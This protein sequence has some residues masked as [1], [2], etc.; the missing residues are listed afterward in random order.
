MEEQVEFD[1]REFRSAETA[2]DR[3]RLGE[4]LVAMLHLG[5]FVAVT[6]HGVARQSDDEILRAARK[7]FRSK[8]SE[9]NSIASVRSPHFRG[10][11]GL[12]FEQTNGRP[13]WRE[14]IEVGADAPAPQIQPGDPP[15]KRLIGPNQWPDGVPE[16]R[17]RVTRWM[18]S[19]GQLGDDVLRCIA[20]GLGQPEDLFNQWF[21]GNRHPM[22]KIVR[23]PPQPRVWRETDGGSDGVGW[24]RDGGFL[25]F[26]LQNAVD[27]LQFLRTT[28]HS[29][30]V[31]T[32]QRVVG[33]YLL[34]TGEALQR[35]TSGYLP[36]AM[37]RVMSPTGSRSRVSIVYF[38]SPGLDTQVTPIHLQRCLS[39]P[40]STGDAADDIRQVFGDNVM[41][42]YIRSHPDVVRIHHPDLLPQRDKEFDTKH[43]SNSAA[44]L[45][46][47][48]SS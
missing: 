45:S 33:A 29:T 39:A 30:T 14:Q 19:M 37:H 5:G 4:Q 34:N 25:T 38:H 46:N 21:G 40:S 6:G 32:P 15:W 20:L 42:Y 17:P 44:G 24:H 18:E 26:I 31:E 36:A 10:Y 22:A 27:G 47:S 43:A 23:Y 2:E 11:T 35:A 3:R 7:F 41:K 9:K 8:A 13:D 12:G 1:I 28:N 48:V 16:M